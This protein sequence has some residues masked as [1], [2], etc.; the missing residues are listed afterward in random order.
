MTM[1]IGISKQLEELQK[2]QPYDIFINFKECKL[3]AK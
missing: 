3:K 1:V 2:K